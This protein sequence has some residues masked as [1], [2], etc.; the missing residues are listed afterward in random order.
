[1]SC[2][3]NEGGHLWRFIDSRNFFVCVHCH[4]IQEAHEEDDDEASG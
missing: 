1:M 4:E 2:P 3:A